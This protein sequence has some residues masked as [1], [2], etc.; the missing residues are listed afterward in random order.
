MPFPNWSPAMVI[1][2]DRLTAMQWQFVRQETNQT[3][4]NSTTLVNTNLIIPVLANGIYRI[5]TYLNFTGSAT[6]DIKFNWSVPAGTTI[7]RF[8]AGPGTAASGGSTD[9]TTTSWRRLTE[10]NDSGISAAGGGVNVSAFEFCQ[11]FIGVTS[12]NIILQFAQNAAN[13]S[14]TILNGQ[15]FVEFIRSE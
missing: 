3:V 10:V 15:S 11:A 9:F 2:A 6:P 4:N 5:N 8:I 12:G 7:Q 13:A 14:D 1:T